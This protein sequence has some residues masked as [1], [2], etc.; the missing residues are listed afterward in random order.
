[1]GQPNPPADPGATPPAPAVPPADP[2][3]PPTP[4]A[5]D[6]K[7]EAYKK[8]SKDLENERKARHDLDAQVKALAPLAKLAEA[9]V[10]KADPGT[11]PAKA[12]QD[13]IAALETEAAT[14]KLTAARLEV[15]TSKGLP[16]AL[17]AR[18]QGS[19]REE[20]EADA[21]ALKALIPAAANGTPATPG[22]P[23]P[24]PSQGS[25]GGGAD[26]QAAIAAAR[27]KGDVME[28]IRLQGRLLD[29]A[30]AKQ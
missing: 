18:L 27:E 1:M 10:P 23:A 20:L 3:T 30:R 12:L 2:A 4:P 7:D 15:A 19:T 22:T 5:T 11:D 26:L 28:S 25:R 8:L 29:E 21:E 13:R 16:P 6:G 17:A 9:L 14:A 24:D